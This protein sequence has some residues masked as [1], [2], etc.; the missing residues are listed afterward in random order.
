MPKI[1][2]LTIDD[3]PSEDCLNKLDFLDAHGI[4][5]VWFAEGQYIKIR[6][7]VAVEILKRGHV[8]G[9]HAYSHPQFSA[10]PLD[11]CFEE[12]LKTHTLLRDIYAAAGVAWT[13]H[14]FRFPFGDKGDGLYGQVDGTLTKRGMERHAAI[15]GLLNSLNYT[16]PAWNKIT[17]E[18]FKSAG[19]HRTRDWYWT[20]DSHD[21]CANSD[22]PVHGID[23]TEKVLARI[24]EDLPFDGRGINYPDSADIVLVHD[25]VTPDDLFQQIIKK[26]LTKDVI[27]KLP[28]S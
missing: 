19:M 25:H 8:L 15:Q 17:Y 14:Y 26:L 6:K 24:D 20:Y 16:Q 4:K 18:H 7:S 12:I 2:Y 21:W 23:S 5:A 3:V 22:H 11:D 10:I 27:F 1:L 9:N 13:N 28:E